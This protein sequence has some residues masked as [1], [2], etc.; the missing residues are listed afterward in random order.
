VVRAT[1][2]TPPGAVNRA[3]EAPAAAAVDRAAA[4]LAAT[5]GDDGRRSRDHHS[6]TKERRMTRLSSLAAG[7]AV[8]LGSVAL[9][10]TAISA[11][12]PKAPTTDPRDANLRA[13][14]ELLRSDVRSQKVAILTEMMEFTEAEDAAFWPIYREYDV[15]LSAINDDRVKLIADYAKNYAALSPESAD[16]IARGALDLEGRRHALK[17]K[18]YDRVKAALAPKQAARF[19]QVEN[20]LLML[21]DLQIAAA[22]PV[23]E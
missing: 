22:L 2:Q 11:Q 17:L 15:E 16:R 18:Y 19:L 23:V 20:Q 12:T 5:G 1:D 3:P 10:A 9:V 6:I 8:L 21:I 7:L 4:F 14:V 13:Y